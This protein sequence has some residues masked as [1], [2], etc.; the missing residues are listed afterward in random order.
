MVDIVP[1]ISFKKLLVQEH[2]QDLLRALRSA[3]LDEA[4]ADVLWAQ[5]WLAVEQ[6]QPD[7]QLRALQDLQQILQ[8]CVAGEAV[9]ACLT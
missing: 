4:Q 9:T 5:A 7:A 6:P 2:F 8:P 1:Q 3:D